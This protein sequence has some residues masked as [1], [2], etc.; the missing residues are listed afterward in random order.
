MR[1]YLDDNITDRRVVAQLQRM[2]H[3][4]RL[5][6][7]TYVQRQCV[8]CEDD[9]SERLKSSVQYFPQPPFLRHAPHVTSGDPPLPTHF[10]QW[11]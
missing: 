8:P 4:V 11:G 1:L 6:T 5:P 2:G 9:A 3:A 10:H 7:E